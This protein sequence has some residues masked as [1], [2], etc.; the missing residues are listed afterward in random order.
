MSV[1]GGAREARLFQAHR[2]QV[3]PPAFWGVAWAGQELRV[4]L[5]Q[6]VFGPRVWCDPGDAAAQVGG[7]AQIL[8]GT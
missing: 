2:A 1:G 4:G 7:H 8:L 3:A 5:F 6:G